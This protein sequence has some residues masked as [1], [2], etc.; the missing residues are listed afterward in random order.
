[1]FVNRLTKLVAAAAAAASIAGLAAGSAASAGTRPGPSKATV[2]ALAARAALRS[3]SA[4]LPV[5]DQLVPGTRRRVGALTKVSYY[6]WAGY[7]DDNSKGN[8]YTKVSGVWTQPAVTCPT[9]EQQIAVFWVGIDGFNN[10]TVEQDGTIAQCFE[11]TAFYYTWWEMYPTNYIQAVG[12]TVKP[13]DKITASV[14]KT[15][16]SYA[17]NLTDST[18]PGN[19]ISTTQT[20][21]AATCA[22]ASAEW[23][24]ET[25]SWPRG[26]VP[27]P[28]FKKWTV[29]SAAVTS[30][31]TSGKISTFPDDE[32]TLV[33]GGGVSNGSYPLGTPSA[34]NSTGNGFGVTWKNSY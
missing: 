4:N 13:G 23:I 24:A 19:N 9:K 34:L 15:G 10:N 25:P 29:S 14:V 2:L 8:T 30:G 11:G 22:A 26:Y 5:T 7:A 18:T 31:T 16:T 28:N 21:A 32:I 17:L 12:T 27:F 6:N 3:M 1:V 33:S 20:C